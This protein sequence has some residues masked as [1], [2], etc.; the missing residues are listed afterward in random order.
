MEFNRNYGD[1]G[2]NPDLELF[3]KQLIAEK[4][5]LSDLHQVAHKPIVSRPPRP[6]LFPLVPAYEAASPNPQTKR[7]AQ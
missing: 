3:L 6:P 5:T 7:T 4:E 1:K 2:R